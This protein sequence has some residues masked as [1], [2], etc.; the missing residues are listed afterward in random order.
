[1]D[2]MKLSRD[3]NYFTI[4]TIG[5][6]SSGK[7]SFISMLKNMK[8]GSISKQRATMTSTL[9]RETDQFDTDTHAA[10]ITALIAK[11]TRL[12][13]STDDDVLRKD[14]A[15]AMSENVVDCERLHL[16]Q[17]RQPGVNIQLLD[18]PG[19][20]DSRT[21]TLYYEHLENIFNRISVVLLIFDINGAMN[22]SDE[23]MILE[24][25]IEFAKQEYD[26]THVKQKVFVIANKC[27]EM[28]YDPV[29]QSLTFV[30]DEDQLLFNQLHARVKAVID[31]THPDLEWEMI[32]ISAENAFIYNQFES[33]AN[34]E[35][36]IA[37][38]EKKYIDKLGVSESG[39]SWHRKNSEEQKHTLMEAL[40][41]PSNIRSAL[42]E[43]G[44]TIFQDKMTEHFTSEKQYEYLLNNLKLYASRMDEE[45]VSD[46]LPDLDDS[47]SDSDDDDAVPS[48]SSAF[49]TKCTYVHKHFE[50]LVNMF[51]GSIDEALYCSFSFRPLLENL[52]LHEKTQIDTHQLT[53]NALSFPMTVESD[54][55]VQH[56]NKLYDLF[57][58]LKT[59]HNTTQHLVLNNG[60]P[61]SSPPRTLRLKTDLFG[62]QGIEASISETL[63][64][65]Y[66][67]LCTCVSLPHDRIHTVLQTKM[68]RIGEDVSHE[69]VLNLCKNETLLAER[70]FSNCESLPEQPTIIRY[71][72][73][74]HDAD[75]LTEAERNHCLSSF[76]LNKYQA[77]LK[78]GTYDFGI[79]MY[80]QRVKNTVWNKL[81]DPTNGSH[82]VGQKYTTFQKHI[83]MSEAL[84]QRALMCPI[85]PN[86]TV[87]ALPREDEEEEDDDA[88]VA[89]TTME[90][91][92]A[93]W[94]FPEAPPGDSPTVLASLFGQQRRSNDNTL[95]RERPTPTSMWDNIPKK[96]RSSGRVLRSNC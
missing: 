18:I 95:K 41:D 21:Q 46:N 63:R 75:I 2:Y 15:N 1:M 6:V 37:S 64:N 9:H 25:T 48:V 10:Q 13:E 70:Q 35:N 93:E 44:Y 58:K 38:L 49:S 77:L 57:R 7:T 94:C 42:H 56:E 23:E 12:R 69:M 84:L 62:F 40:S 67:Q 30:E 68:G 71:C 52:L 45:S 61:G 22:T 19:L 24:R 5:A 39:K 32:K 85:P 51:H 27:D 92:C 53:L 47:D 16:L 65:Y 89:Y 17:N 80:L 26:K 86:F 31:E 14:L 87:L 90:A 34:I 59:M 79:A 76:I 88:D 60:S 55:V 78:T 54:T 74:Y 96:V 91:V 72:Q 28:K 11:D 33:N 8:S 50:R 83:A 73:H 81:L 3:S 82:D 36:G 29:T 20:N 66:T 43:S 4:A